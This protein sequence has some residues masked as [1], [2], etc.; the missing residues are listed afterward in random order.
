LINITTRKYREAVASFE[1]HVNNVQL[2]S[3]DKVRFCTS[4]KNVLKN[5]FK[6]YTHVADYGILA[7]FVHLADQLLADG[8]TLEIFNIFSCK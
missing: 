4:L 1:V 5:V 3:I 7:D 6:I 8:S 2:K